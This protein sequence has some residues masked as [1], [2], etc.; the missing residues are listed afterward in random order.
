M[1]ICYIVLFAGIHAI[2]VDNTFSRFS[3]KLIYFYI[4]TY[5]VDEWHR[6][7]KDLQE[8]D[9]SIENA[10]VSRASYGHFVYHSVGAGMSIK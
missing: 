8:F 7:T 10:T 5:V 4:V 6:F 1:Y 2:C 3:S 9:I